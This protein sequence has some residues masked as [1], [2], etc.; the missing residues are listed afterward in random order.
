MSHF[1]LLW[2][3]PI[4]YDHLSA[5][6]HY[7]WAKGS[8]CTVWLFRYSMI[9]FPKTNRNNFLIFFSWLDIVIRCWRNLRRESLRARSTTSSTSPLQFSS[10]STTKTFSK[11]SIREILVSQR[12][13]FSSGKSI[14]IEPTIAELIQ[15]TATLKQNALVIRRKKPVNYA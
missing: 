9:F 13:P 2:Q 15:Y 5:T 14:T 4:Y 7:F 11:N 3:L 8:R 1:K 6:A 10:T 12:R